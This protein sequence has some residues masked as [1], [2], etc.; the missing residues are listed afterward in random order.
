MATSTLLILA[1]PRQATGSI[2]PTEADTITAP[3][4]RL[5]QVLHRGR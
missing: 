4:Y 3:R 2:S 1:S 5:G